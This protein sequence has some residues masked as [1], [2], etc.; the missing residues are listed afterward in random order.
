MPVP[1]M[2][3]GHVGVLMGEFIVLMKM[4]MLLNGCAFMRV[5]MMPIIMGMGMFMDHLFM[6]MLMRMFL[7]H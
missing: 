5:L 2:Q 1:M 4:R 3:I 7:I 6:H